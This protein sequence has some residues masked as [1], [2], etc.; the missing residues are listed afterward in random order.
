MNHCGQGCS[1]GDSCSLGKTPCTVQSPGH[2]PPPCHALLLRG[3][4]SLEISA[5]GGKGLEEICFSGM[6]SLLPLPGILTIFTCP[7]SQHHHKLSP[8]TH[9]KGFRDP[10]AWG[11]LP[12]PQLL[13]KA[14]VWVPCELPV[15]AAISVVTRAA[16]VAT[17]CGMAL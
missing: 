2:A 10:M 11:T 7:E 14:C 16:G 13:P 3:P 8:H 1:S 15:P 17:V 4:S 5:R 9:P 6:G 12:T